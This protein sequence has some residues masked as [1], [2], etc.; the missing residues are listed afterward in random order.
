MEIYN[1]VKIEELWSVQRRD[2]SIAFG[3]SVRSVER[4]VADTGCNFYSM[5]CWRCYAMCVTIAGDD[6]LHREEV[7]TDGEQES[8]EQQEEEAGD[9]NK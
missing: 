5:L 8:G 2:Y 4:K 6:E 9:S 7:L 3:S 1:N